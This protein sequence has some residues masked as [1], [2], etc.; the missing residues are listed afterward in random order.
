MAKI[1]ANSVQICLFW[2]GSLNY[3]Q[4][5][6]WPADIKAI[7]MAFAA[8]IMTLRQR[9]G[10]NVPVEM[11]VCPVNIDQNAVIVSQH[12]L[13]FSLLP[14]AQIFGSYPDGYNS[15]Y[16]LSQDLGDRFS[17]VNWKEKD[18][19]P[20]IEALLYRSK[21]A[22]NSIVCKLLPPLCDIGVWV[23]F[24]LAVGATLKASGTKGVSK[25]AWTGGAGLLWWEWYQRGGVKQLTSTVGIGKYYDDVTIKP[26]SRVDDYWGNLSP[27]PSSYGVEDV[28]GSHFTNVAQAIK[29]FGLYSIEFGN[30][31][32]QEERLNFM[33]STLVTLR[34]MAKV[35]GAK[36]SEM[37]LRKKL[38][39]AFGS[40]GKGG[41]AAAFYQS[42]YQ[43]IN[44]TKTKGRGT[45]CHEYAH[46]VDD[47]LG[48]H[49]GWRSTRKQPDYTGKRKGSAAWLFETVLDKVLW[50][51]NGNPSS[52]QK[53]LEGKGD[54]LNRRNEIFAR[55]CETFFYMKFKS[56]GVKNSWGG[57]MR[58]DMPSMELVVRADSEIKQIFQKI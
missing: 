54:Y 28:S 56:S 6:Q 47:F 39:I 24:G 9:H 10:Q 22:P 15:K 58:G 2:H 46:A 57:T 17:G 35:V 8:A 20:Y 31:L 23:W 19:L 38:S 50:L 48:Q 43:V 29:Q 49:S 44:L 1:A 52:Y 51:P 45:F 14:A 30:W 36:Q 5:D 41:R 55:I 26:G 7:W 18:V 16:F 40:R 34:D 3:N 12:G 13:D 42:G 21:P 53:F 32:N 27:S 4:V 25:A 37:G 33:Y 11:Y